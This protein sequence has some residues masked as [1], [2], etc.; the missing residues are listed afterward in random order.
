MEMMRKCD[1]WSESVQIEHS[2]PSSSNWTF[3]TMISMWYLIVAQSPGGD[4][5]TGGCECGRGFGD[6]RARA[7]LEPETGTGRAVESPA[8]RDRRVGHS[9]NNSDRTQR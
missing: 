1:A 4:G 9:G 2:S 8:V 5:S 7:R 3:L 6:Q